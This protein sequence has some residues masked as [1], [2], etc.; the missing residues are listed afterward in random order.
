MNEAID[1]KALGLTAV[2][3]KLL[4]TKE[5]AAFLRVSTRWIEMHVKNG[6]FPVKSYSVGFRCRVFN[7]EDIENWLSKITTGAGTTPLPKK[8][9]RKIINTKEVAVNK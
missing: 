6:T 8:A 5:V 3:G 1:G 7:S 2:K 4:T 9:E